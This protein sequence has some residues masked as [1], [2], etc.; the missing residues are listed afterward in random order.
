MGAKGV[1]ESTHDT[2]D[3]S[4]VECHGRKILTLRS[5]GIPIE[6]DGIGD[7]KLPCPLVPCNAEGAMVRLSGIVRLKPRYEGSS[8]P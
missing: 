3:V 7:A 5:G 4:I 2:I 8:E 6:Y 1:M